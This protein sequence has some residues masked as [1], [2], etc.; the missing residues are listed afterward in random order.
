M[1]NNEAF[2]QGLVPWSVSTQPIIII[3]IVNINIF[4][5]S[6]II[7]HFFYWFLDCFYC[8]PSKIHLFFAVEAAILL[9]YEKFGFNFVF[10]QT[11][12]WNTH[13]TFI[14]LKYFLSPVDFTWDTKNI[15]QLIIFISLAYIT[16]IIAIFQK[17]S[18]PY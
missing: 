5:I 13:T 2:E 9:P 18:F 6:Y 1:S 7:L 4:L 3:H 10:Y 15:V 8:F 17:K 16:D 11:I 14:S 12:V